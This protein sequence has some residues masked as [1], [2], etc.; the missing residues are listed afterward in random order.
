MY[1]M[2]TSE[3]VVHSFVIRVWLEETAVAPQQARWR[4]QI[5]HI[6]SKQQRYI[7][8]LDAVLQ[9]M[10]PYLRSLGVHNSK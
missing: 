9:F 10:T 6:P 4:G 3:N 7:E 5:T 1:E 2:E 8:D